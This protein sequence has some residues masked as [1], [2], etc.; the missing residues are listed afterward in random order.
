MDLTGSHATQLGI[1]LLLG[2]LLFV[3]VYGIAERKIIGLLI[4]MIPFQLI[5]SRYGSINMVLT[6]LIGLSLVF[7][8]SI[9]YLPLLP[10]V[11]GIL[12][13]YFIS[14]ALAL[15]P[16]WIDHVLYIISIT[17]NFVLFYIVYNHFRDSGDVKFAFKLLTWMNVLVVIYGLIQII[18]GPDKFAFLGIDEF[19][20]ASN[21]TEKQRLV[22]TFGAPGI[23]AEYFALQIL[24]LGYLFM[25]Y[26]DK[27]TKIFLLCLMMANF[28]LIVA[29]GSRGS[30]L[31]LM[32]GIVL[33]LWFFRKQLGTLVLIRIV[34]IGSLLFVLM[35]V[36]IIKY[37]QFNVL[38]ER[39]GDTELSESGVPDT[40]EFAFNLALDRI[41][42]AMIFGHGPQLRL[43]DEETRRIVGYQSMPG[44]PHNLYLFLLYTLGSVGLFA[45]TVF[46]YLVLR[47]FWISRKTQVDDVFIRGIPML[48]ILLLIV[49][50]V[51]QLKIEF[52]RLRVNDMQHYLFTLWAI[53]LAFTNLK[54]V[55]AEEKTKLNDNKDETKEVST[56]YPRLRK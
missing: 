21:L 56:R 46:F 36:V 1:A 23:N 45:Y 35:A 32:G 42:D 31:S 37:T 48:G 51:D 50:F 11:I 47:Q 54:N 3:M 34:G 20:F 49:F 12:A 26:Q 44:Y 27:R 40:R 13:A 39:L 19:S 22:G 9:R 38:F 6:Y 10:A 25:N 43:I 30:F 8:G 4:I 24:L 53:L 16:T 17:S 15:R 41:P 18:I 55:A 52:L 14:T 2:I 29:T 7:K 28:A 5:S 33:F